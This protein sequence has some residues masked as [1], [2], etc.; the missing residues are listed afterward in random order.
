MDITAVFGTVVGGS[1]PSGCTMEKPPA[2]GFSIV[3]PEK[4]PAHLLGGTRSAQPY[5]E[6][7]ASVDETH[8]GFEEVQRIIL[9]DVSSSPS[10][11]ESA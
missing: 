5:R 4:V 6:A 3:H 10:K 7:M 11:I 2:G 9:S 8:L 1:S